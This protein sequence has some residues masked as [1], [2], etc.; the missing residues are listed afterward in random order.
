MIKN[1]PFVSVIIPTY[2]DWER[3]GYVCT[4]AL[5]KKQTYPK[6]HFEAIIINNAPEDS[7][8]EF[9]L[10]DN[11]KIISESKPGSYAA[12]N[13]GVSVA[14]GEIIAFTD[15]DCIPCPDWIE[16]GVKFFGERRSTCCRKSG[17]I[18]QIR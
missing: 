12:R 16:Q 1:M 5:F 10:P 3:L 4:N 8:P 17:A 14:R 6:D 15:S 11:F 9:N 13:K 7:S 2:H 18:L